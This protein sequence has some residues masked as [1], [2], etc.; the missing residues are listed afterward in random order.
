MFDGANIQINLKTMPNI[1]IKVKNI[2]GC[3][4]ANNLHKAVKI[5]EM[6]LVIDSLSPFSYLY[7]LKLL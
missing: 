4:E 3:D 1:Y 2:G 6:L 5:K 7:L